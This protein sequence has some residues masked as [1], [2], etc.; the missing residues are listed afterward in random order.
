MLLGDWGK[1]ARKKRMHAVE[2]SGELV[3]IKKDEASIIHIF[4]GMRPEA[5]PR[6]RRD[7]SVSVRLSN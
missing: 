6:A 7:Y 5:R 2:L 3:R 1:V 4:A